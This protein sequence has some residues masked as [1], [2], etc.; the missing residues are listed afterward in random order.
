MD[1]LIVGER[2]DE[3]L[4]VGVHHGEGD[5]IVVVFAVHGVLGEVLQ[6]VVHPAHVP[7]QGEAKTTLFGGG[8]HARPGG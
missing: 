6:G 4:R 8:G 2:Q 3:L 5:L 7:L 1:D